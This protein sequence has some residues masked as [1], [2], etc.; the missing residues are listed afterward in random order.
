MITFGNSRFSRDNRGSITAWETPLS[1]SPA[2]RAE[3]AL[4]AESPGPLSP[5]VLTRHGIVTRPAYAEI[6]PRVEYR[7]TPLGEGLREVL[8]AMAAWAMAVPDSEPTVTV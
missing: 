2:A 5:S 7:L 6:P 8:D 3:T 1:A 4:S